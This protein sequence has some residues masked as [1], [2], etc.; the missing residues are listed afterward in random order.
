MRRSL[1]PRSKTPRGR[2]DPLG[3]VANGGGVHSVPRLDVLQQ[4]RTELDQAQRRLA[5][6][7]DG[8]H[9]GAVGVVGTDATVAVTVECRRVAAAPA[10]T[11]AGDQIDERRFLGLLQ[12][13]PHSSAGAGSGGAARTARDS[14]DPGW[15]SCRQYR[16]SIR[17]GQEGR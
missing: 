16:T 9:A 14:L 10:V 7:D 13:I 6:G 1:V 5:P 17:A 4:D 3:Q 2:P 8:V 12:L 15:W 11:L